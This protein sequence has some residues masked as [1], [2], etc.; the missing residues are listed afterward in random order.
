[1][2]IFHNWELKS[3]TFTKQRYA[4]KWGTNW[5]ESIVLKLWKCKKCGK[6]RA[7]KIDEDNNITEINADILMHNIDG[8]NH[9]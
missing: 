3:T 7:M 9:A 2:H 4:G 8:A 1:M 5:T 6:L